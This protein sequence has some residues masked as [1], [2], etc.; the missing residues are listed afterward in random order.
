[1]HDSH[2]E[3]TH[4]V[5]VMTRMKSL[6]LNAECH[7]FKILL[8]VI[9]V[10]T[11][12]SALFFQRTTVEQQCRTHTHTV[13]HRVESQVS[14]PQISRGQTWLQSKQ[15]WRMMGRK[16]WR[17]LCLN[18]LRRNGNK[19][20]LG[21]TTLNDVLLCVAIFFNSQFA[22]WWAIVCHGSLSSCLLQSSSQQ[23]D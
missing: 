4:T 19:Q 20:I 22:S 13:H 1:M 2:Y 6:T 7:E 23:I 9:S 11:D 10:M 21:S 18:K 15:T 12:L 3:R 5:C 17:F 8:N 14:K 16:T